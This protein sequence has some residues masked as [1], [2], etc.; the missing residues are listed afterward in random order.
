MLAAHLLM[1]LACAGGSSSGAP[2]S[3][4]SAEALDSLDLAGLFDSNGGPQ[5]GALLRTRGA[6]TR[7]FDA[8]PASGE[9]DLAGFTL[10]VARVSL[11]GSVTDRY[12]YYFAV[13]AGESAQQDSPFAG[14]AGS[15]SLLDAYATVKLCDWASLRAGQFCMRF[16]LSSCLDERDILFLDR[17]F[18]GESMDNRDR[19]LELSGTFGRFDWWASANDGFDGT[20]DEFAF[21]GRASCRLLG[22][23]ACCAE[24]ALG[25][26][27]DS[28]TLGAGWFDDRSMDDGQVLGAELY[29]AHA[30]WSLAAEIADYG[31]DMQ[32]MPQ[33][34]T[35]TG[36]LLPGMGGMGGA[37]T[38]W[39]VT[40]GYVIPQSSWQ[41]AGRYQQLEDDAQTSIFSFVVNQHVGNGP[42]RWSAQYDHVTSDDSLLEV[43]TFAIGLTVAI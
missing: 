14:P 10:D 25:V 33:V 19:G 43:E 11:S 22:E 31:D 2:A 12:G 42:M 3:A 15:A 4:G 24:G 13:E 8:D 41:F 30:G 5:L 32:P 21:A 9:Q 39:A 27:D 37:E 29:A 40:L 36:I 6:T 34:S 35:T 20:Q 26:T 28:L 38:P 18:I 1:A 7:E 16:L 23:K 17:S